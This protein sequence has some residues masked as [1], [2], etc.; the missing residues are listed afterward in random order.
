MKKSTLILLL[1]AQSLCAQITYVGD[2]EFDH[3]D[4]NIKVMDEFMLRF[5]LQNAMIT[6]EQDSMWRFDNRVL[7]FDKD[8]YYANQG[9]ADSLIHAI[10]EQNVKISFQDSTW[11][12]LARCQVLFKEKK[13][14]IDL[15]LK[16]EKVKSD[17]YKWSIVDASGKIVELIP[18]TK[19]DRLR[20]LP[21]DND[22]DF[23]SLNPITT[24]NSP[25]IVLYSKNNYTVDRLSVFNALV[26]NGLL[27][28]QHVKELIYC[29]ESVQGF[30]FYVKQFTRDSRNAGYLIY[31]IERTTPMNNNIETDIQESKENEVRT[32]EKTIKTFYHMLS[33]YAIEP[34][35]LSLAREIQGLF[36][37]NNSFP[38]IFGIAHL[39]NDVD[40]I[41]HCQSNKTFVS[42]KE[43]LFSLAECVSRHSSLKFN[44]HE[45]KPIRIR[46][47]VIE[48]QY[49][50]TI[51]RNNEMIY[52][53]YNK[54]KL[55]DGNIVCIE[56]LLL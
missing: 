15:V 20:I 54:M 37:N 38:Y 46:Q 47:N 41:M 22:V 48:M 2:A 5:N 1:I 35:N 55:K 4:Y 53:V 42:I 39:Y 17:I 12:A 3:F 34:N 27:Q 33:S 52:S 29:F 24:I 50:L 56:P 6:P 31:H 36:I 23:M 32:A 40:D 21:T 14:S 43:Y 28:I 13:D 16:T 19:S 51:Y 7:L 49:K 8:T 45:I 25:N 26:Y 10:E 44:I 30:R 9:L 18:K 11:Y